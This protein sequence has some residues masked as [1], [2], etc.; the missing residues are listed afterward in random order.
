MPAAKDNPDHAADRFAA[1]VDPFTSAGRGWSNWLR[2]RARDNPSGL[3]GGCDLEGWFDRLFG[4][5]RRRD[6]D[7]RLRLSRRWPVFHRPLGL[8]R[9]LH[10]RSRA[11][12][13]RY[14]LRGFRRLLKRDGTRSERELEILL[15]AFIHG[16]SGLRACCEKQRSSETGSSDYRTHLSSNSSHGDQP[17]PQWHPARLTAWP[18]NGRTVAYSPGIA[19]SGVF[20][21]T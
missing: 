4:H 5:A 17:V 1:L 18:C 2:P 16:L 9:S 13:R 20:L 7:R 15:Q 10:L 11:F 8:D 3:L 6:L 19:G 21:S 12:D 14:H